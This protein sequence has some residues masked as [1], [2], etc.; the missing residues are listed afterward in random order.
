MNSIQM[1]LPTGSD[2][3]V[4]RKRAGSDIHEVPAATLVVLRACAA[5]NAHGVPLDAILRMF[6]RWEHD[7]SSVR[8]PAGGLF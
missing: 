8:I 6:D 7:P 3:S 4:G 5:R 2:T 1:A